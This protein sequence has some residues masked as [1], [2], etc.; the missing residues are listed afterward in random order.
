MKRL[1]LAVAV[2][3]ALS[4]AGAPAAWA[5]TCPKLYKR[6]TDAIAKAEKEKKIDAEKA[7][8][9]KKC[10]DDGH[11]LHE[12]GKHDES[13]KALKKCLKDMGEKEEV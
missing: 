8:A 7:T 3:F 9:W 10:A 2:A 4:M 11:K 5:K 13:V 1:V 6:A 12:E